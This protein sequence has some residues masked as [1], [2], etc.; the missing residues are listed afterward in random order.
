[1]IS[2]STF[3][4]HRRQDVYGFDAEEF[5]PERWDGLNARWEFLPFSAGPKV[6]MG[7]TY[8]YAEM[9][10]ILSRIVQEFERVERRSDEPWMEKWS[11]TLLNASGTKVGLVPKI[12]PLDRLR[13]GTDT[14]I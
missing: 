12:R 6:C 11:I 2:C 7:Q 4:L 10:Y 14:C 13:D 3:S 9:V 8:A 1:M 5:R